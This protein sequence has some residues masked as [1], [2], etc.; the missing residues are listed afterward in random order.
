MNTKRKERKQ[1]V[2]KIADC[3]LDN[4]CGR[5]VQWTEEARLTIKTLAEAEVEDIN[6]AEEDSKEEDSTTKA[7]TLTAV[8]EDSKEEVSNNKVEG[9]EEAEATSTQV[10][11]TSKNHLALQ[12]I[13]ALSQPIRRQ[14]PY[15]EFIPEPE[16]KLW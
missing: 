3:I 11:S 13:P 8:E 5:I 2:T 10:I 16:P 15:T 14:S 12:M 9:L 7:E 6:K 4:T 1:L